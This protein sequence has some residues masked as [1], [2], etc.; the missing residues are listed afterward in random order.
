MLLYL[1]QSGQLLQD[2]PVP[3]TVL[4]GF[5][6]KRRRFT[7]FIEML[8]ETAPCAGKS[9]TPLT[10]VFGSGRIIPNRSGPLGPEKFG[11]LSAGVRNRE[12]PG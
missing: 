4:L 6:K 5:E 8:V 9:R 2:M 3:R 11:E 7:L 10:P 12:D 1:P